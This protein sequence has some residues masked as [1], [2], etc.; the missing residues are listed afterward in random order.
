[1]QLDFGNIGLSEERNIRDALSFGMVST[2]TPQVGQFEKQFAEYLGV[3]GSVATNS[4]TAALHLALLVCGIG[5]GDEV[6]LPATTFV[7]TANAVVHAG[8]KPVFV[9]VDLDTWNIDPELVEE[10]VTLKTK[11]ILPVHLY[12]NPCDMGAL[13]EI[14]KTHM[15]YII[16]D[17]AES[18]GATYQD[19]Q[20]GTIGDVGCFSFNGNKLMTTG[21]GGMLVS[22]DPEK[23]QKANWLS[24]QGRNDNLEQVMIGYNYRMPGLNASL[25]LAQLD[26]I[27]DFLVKK[28]AFQSH[29]FNSLDCDVVFQK[30]LADSYPSWWYTACLF[31]QE[32][33]IIQ[34]RL[35]ALAIPTRRVFQPVP[36]ELPYCYCN[37][38]PNAEYLYKHG[39][40]L[41]CSTLNTVDD[42][43]RVCEGIRGILE[44]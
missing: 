1:M 12:G 31:R 11:A 23:L 5:P 38:Y 39:L 18:L 4:C 43:E 7:A 25:G 9:D 36:Y 42:I 8:A 21:G 44:K 28:R 33:E 15:L 41:P 26:R 6:I 40:C 2:D 19:R 24:R 13:Y 27:D 32:A 37:N 3:A 14:A 10:A 35:S 34:D 20:T 17:A 30:K 22:N 16:E 29:Y